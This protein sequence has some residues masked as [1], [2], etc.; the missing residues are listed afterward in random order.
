MIIPVYCANC[1]N[2]THPQF[3]L[4]V[5]TFIHGIFIFSRGMFAKHRDHKLTTCEMKHG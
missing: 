5:G 2:V 1:S 3:N 4:L